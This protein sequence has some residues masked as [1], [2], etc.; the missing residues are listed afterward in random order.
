M[1][2]I[3][4][5]K[6]C[7][8]PI[9]CGDDCP[10]SPAAFCITLAGVNYTPEDCWRY[11]FFAA[12]TGYVYLHLDAIFFWPGDLTFRVTRTT[13]CRWQ[14]TREAASS[15]IVVNRIGA[16]SCDGDE[17]YTAVTSPVYFTTTVEDTGDG[18]L[19]I[20]VDA[21]QYYFG[22]LLFGEGRR[23][24]HA[25]IAKPANWCTDGFTAFNDHAVGS[26]IT[27][28]GTPPEKW[29]SGGTITAVPGTECPPCEDCTG[30]L[31]RRRWWRYCCGD[32]GVI[33]GDELVIDCHAD[34][35]VDVTDYYA[36]SGDVD[37][38]VCACLS[39]WGDPGTYLVAD[40]DYVVIEEGASCD[41]EITP[42]CSSIEAGPPDFIP[43]G[44]CPETYCWQEDQ[45]VWDCGLDEWVYFATTINCGFAPSVCVSCG[46]GEYYSADG[47][48]ASIITRKR[49]C[50]LTDL[51]DANC[52][53]VYLDDAAGP[54]SQDPSAE[55][56]AAYCDEYS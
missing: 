23:I 11:F 19:E 34:T 4:H 15:R 2:G 13:G 9:P 42:D 10:D 24:F 1:P 46:E 37:T 6:C 7:C 32:Y 56:I 38:C 41:N 49:V 53:D 27:G 5:R 22:L 21:Y 43:D 29:A 44:P 47:I 39:P 20:T 54:P 18:N 55:Q 14:C 3:N 45:W 36:A 51:D 26:E 52:T 25:R 16:V 17:I 30:K 31:F 12:G 40:R 28:G 48:S 35:W 50:D 8:A 33:I